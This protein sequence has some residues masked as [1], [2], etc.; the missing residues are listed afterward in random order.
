M[1]S[2]ISKLT[3]LLVPEEIKPLQDRNGIK[4]EINSKTPFT[5]KIISKIPGEDYIS[6]LKETQES[7]YENGKKDGIQTRWYRNGQKQ[8]EIN[9]KNGELDGLY[10]SWYENGRRRYEEYYRNGKLDDGACHSWYKNGQKREERYWKNGK[11]DGTQ[12]FWDEIGWKTISHF[13]DGKQEGFKT[14]WHKNGQ[15]RRE[16]PYK[17]GKKEGL[18]TR[19]WEN[20]QKKE[21]VNYKDGKKEGLYRTW[22]ENGRG[23]CH[24]Y[25]K[26]G[27][28][29]GIHT[30][31]DGDGKMSHQ[32]IYSYGR[33]IEE[34]YK[35]SFVHKEVIVDKRNLKTATLQYEQGLTRPEEP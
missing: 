20:G 26:N 5:G 1:K 12:T 35:L 21:E 30:E 28:E 29:D 10:V 23:W 31:Y 33:M 15:K 18:H 19:W 8:T 3:S 25:Y 32:E 14:G 7:Y 9:Y 24:Y 6:S 13:K 27:K 17:N 11:L 4:Y 22:W 2:I 34:I 16:T